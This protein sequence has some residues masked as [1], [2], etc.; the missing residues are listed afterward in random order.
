MQILGNCFH[1][2]HRFYNRFSFIFLHFNLKHL[3]SNHIP[4]HRRGLSVGW[5]QMRTDYFL[6]IFMAQL[7]LQVSGLTI[8]A[9][10]RVGRSKT[11][12]VLVEVN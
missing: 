12:F 2:Q 11:Y 7:T 8:A 10:C 3:F 6:S 9:A 4:A 1:Y 5:I